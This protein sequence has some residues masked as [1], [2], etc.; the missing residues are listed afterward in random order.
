ML[1]NVAV[2][3]ENAW[4]AEPDTDCDFFPSVYKDRILETLFLKGRCL[5]IS[6]YDLKLGSVHME[7]MSAGLHHA[8][9]VPDD[10][11][12]AC[13]ETDLLIDSIH[14]K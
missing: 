3:H 13:I 12:F 9:N 1:K 6:G 10:P 8:A 5:T 11:D 4:V 2:V 7:G 14:V